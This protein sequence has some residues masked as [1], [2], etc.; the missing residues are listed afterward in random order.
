MAINIFYKVHIQTAQTRASNGLQYFQLIHS[1]KGI[2][3]KNEPRRRRS[4]S[5]PSKYRFCDTLY[6]LNEQH[7]SFCNQNSCDNKDL[8]INNAIENCI[9]LALATKYEA[10]HSDKNLPRERSRRDVTDVTGYN[11]VVLNAN[12]SSVALHS[13]KPFMNYTV[14]LQVTTN[15]GSGPLSNPILVQTGEDGMLIN[16]IISYKL[17]FII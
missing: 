17:Q 7:H 15:K 3:T 8:A 1:S 9:S 11:S 14:L 2:N 16:F 4:I 6:H 13:L 12:E 10:G 5:V